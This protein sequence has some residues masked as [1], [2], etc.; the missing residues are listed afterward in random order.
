[1]KR[2]LLL[3]LM[4]LPV[5][6]QALPDFVAGASIQF[7]QASRPQSQGTV[8]AAKAV[9][10]TRGIY[11]YNL[12]RIT[13][14]TFDTKTHTLAVQKQ[15]E[16]GAA[17]YVRSFDLGPSLGTWGCYTAITG[18]IALAGGDKGASGSGTLFCSRSIGK[19]FSTAVYFG[20]S[21][22]ALANGGGSAGVSYPVGVSLF[23]GGNL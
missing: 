6:G 10:K 13:S 5:F 8:F 2:I 23:W 14:I 18:G 3:A 22:S 11:S 21:Y 20:P 16:T 9:D 12:L 19:G 4:A 7:N 1:M 15:A 17:F